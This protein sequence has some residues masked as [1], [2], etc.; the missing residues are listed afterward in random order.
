TG[1][2]N[3]LCA[4]TEEGLLAV[5]LFAVKITDLKV[6]NC[7]Q[8]DSVATMVLLLDVSVWVLLGE[9]KFHGLGVCV[10][11]SLSSLSSL[12]SPFVSSCYASVLGLGSFFELVCGPVAMI[13]PA[14]AT[15]TPGLCKDH[16]P[17]PCSCSLMLPPRLCAILWREMAPFVAFSP[18]AI[19]FIANKDPN[20]PVDAVIELPCLFDHG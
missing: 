20:L 8:N 13:S 11:V 19:V 15:Q 3:G 12:L 7:D 9:Q 18:R 16:L 14:V 4:A 17:M 2:R 10:T 6:V 1:S 5:K